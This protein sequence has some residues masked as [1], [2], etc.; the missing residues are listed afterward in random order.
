MS[1]EMVKDDVLDGKIELGLDV[2]K[3]DFKVVVDEILKVVKVVVLDI[4][5]EVDVELV[6]VDVEE[7]VL[8][9]VEQ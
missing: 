6:D 9:M 7:V 3:V 8:L 4:D 1:D 2:S 5:V